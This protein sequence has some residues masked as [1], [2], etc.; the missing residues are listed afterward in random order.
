M[1][2]VD[3]YASSF[4]QRLSRVYSSLHG[5]GEAGATHQKLSCF[6]NKADPSSRQEE[7]LRRDT[8]STLASKFMFQSLSRREPCSPL[9]RIYY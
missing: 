8:S 9:P 6:P 2:F 7:L 4:L 3:I 1:L 5:A